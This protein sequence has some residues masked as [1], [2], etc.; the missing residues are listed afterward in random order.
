MGDVA[1][2][3]VVVSVYAAAVVHE[4]WG[5]EYL[6]GIC[7][8]ECC[9]FYSMVSIVFFMGHSRKISLW[10]NGLFPGYVLWIHSYEMFF[11]YKRH[12]LSYLY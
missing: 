10:P 1:A 12:N 6:Y 11:L 9:F 3:G 8:N 5:C 2:F 7:L 4:I